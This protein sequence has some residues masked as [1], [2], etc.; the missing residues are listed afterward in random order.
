MGHISTLLQQC[1]VDQGESHSHACSVVSR[2]QRRLQSSTDGYDFLAGNAPGDGDISIMFASNITPRRKTRVSA[3]SRRQLVSSFFSRGSLSAARSNGR[4]NAF[5]GATSFAAGDPAH[6]TRN[7]S[8]N[9]PEGWNDTDGAGNCW[10]PPS[11]QGPCE[12]IQVRGGESV[13]EKEAHSHRCRVKWPCVPGSIPRSN[14]RGDPIVRRPQDFSQICP[15]NWVII[16]KGGALEGADKP[17]YVCKAPESYTGPCFPV[18]NLK[19]LTPSER[20]QWSEI[21]K[22]RWPEKRSALNQ[23][24]NGEDWTYPCPRGWDHAKKQRL[25]LAPPG[26]RAAGTKALYCPNAVKVFE[27]AE[28]KRDFVENCGLD[29]WS[30]LKQGECPGG[31]THWSTPCA[32]GWRAFKGFCLPPVDKTLFE[33]TTKECRHP[34]FMAD[35]ADAA[36]LKSVFPKRAQRIKVPSD[37][38]EKGKFMFGVLCNAVWPC[39]NPEDNNAARAGLARNADA[40][41]F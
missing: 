36:Y 23:C 32:R 19:D 2:K 27:D 28:D 39:D 13:S 14:A 31:S 21:C 1:F 41:D 25:C 8:R 4:R 33:K 40:I 7:Y 6:C 3:I 34:W 12:N 9:C 15:S 26:W 29:G 35:V 30:C 5:D 22:E 16:K 11:Y 18:Q 10:P 20:R 17:S 37:V 24:P 38:V